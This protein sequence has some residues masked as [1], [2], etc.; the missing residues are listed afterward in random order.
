VLTPSFGRPSTRPA[1]G[2]CFIG[3]RQ[4]RSKVSIALRRLRR[5][6]WLSISALTLPRVRHPYSSKMEN[7]PRS[8]D[9]ISKRVDE[10]VDPVRRVRRARGEAAHLIFQRLK[11]ADM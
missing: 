11:R 6:P 4:S 1:G 9:Q 7:G 5:W 2:L 3:L 8:H 10:R